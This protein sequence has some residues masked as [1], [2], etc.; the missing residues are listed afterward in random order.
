MEEES[1]A[2]ENGETMDQKVKLIS[3]W[4]G[5]EYGITELSINSG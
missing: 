1:H 2:L 5:N 3:L 4:L